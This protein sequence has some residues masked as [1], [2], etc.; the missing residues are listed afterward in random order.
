MS[1]TQ[2]QQALLIAEAWQNLY[3]NQSY[4]D[5]QSYSQDN[6]V[7]AILNYV[8]V[9]YPDNFNDW[10]ANSEFVIK[11]RT[12]AWLHQNISYRIDLDIRENFIQTATRR[13]AILMLAEN[14]FYRPNRVTGASGELRIDSIKTNQPL[15]DSNSDALSNVEI[16]WNDPANPDWF[17]QFMLV[18]NA[19]L[20]PRTQ[21]GHPLSR[22]NNT[23]TR[24]D[25]YMFNSRAPSGGVYPFTIQ[26]AGTSLPFGYI[27]VTMD[28]DTGV[29]S[30]IAPNP[31]NALRILYRSDGR[32]SGSSGTGFFL[33][34]RQGALTSFDQNFTV[35]QAMSSVILGTANVDNGNVFVQQL[36]TANNVVL[37]WTEVESIFGQG[38]SFNTLNSKIQTIF[39]THTLLNDQVRVQFG[40]GKFGAIPTDR[41]RFWYR[42][43][44]PSPIAIQP[45]DITR[46]N[47]TIPY[48]NNGTLYFLTVRA[49]LVA[50][51][52]NAISTDSNITIKNNTGGAFAAQNRMVTAADYN[53]FPLSDPSILKLKTVNRTYS[54]HSPYA[55]ISDP[56][57]FYTGI[58]ILGEDGRLYRDDA[59][60]S[61]FISGL[62]SQITLDEIVLRYLTPL[63]QST[64]KFSLYY[65]RYN[66]I[67]CQGNPV[68][69]QT[70][71][72]N[73]ISS[74]NIKKSNAVI[75]VGPT[76]IDEFFYFIAGT[77]VRYN[78]LSGPLIS[79]EHIVG[80]GTA[81]DGIMLTGALAD[82]TPIYSLMPPLRN[83]FTNA[84]QSAIKSQLF[85][86]Q[87]FGLSWNQTTQAWTIISNANLDKT[88]DFSLD[89][90]GDTTN[91][92]KDG[93]W[94]IFLRYIPNSGNG[95]EWEIVDRGMG[96][97]F[98]SSRSVDFA[99]V[100]TGPLV[101]PDT[102][103]L[104][105][106]NV[107]I[108]G[109]NEAR[110][111]LHRLGLFQIGS[112]CPLIFDF[113]AGGVA[114]CFQ[115][116]ERVD[117]PHVVV[118]LDGQ[119]QIF[120]NDYTIRETP[121]G[122]EICFFTA[123]ARGQIVSIRMNGAYVY[124][125]QELVSTIADGVTRFYP[126]AANIRVN[127]HNTFLSL[128]GVTQGFGDYLT[129]NHAQTAGFLITPPPFVN[130][131][132]QG[133]AEAGPTTDIFT[134]S[135][136]VGDGST[137]T[138]DTNGQGETKDKVVVFI[139]G[140]WQTPGLDYN[141]DNVSSPPNTLLQFITAPA[142]N[143]SVV[144]H[145][146]TIP[147]LVRS[148]FFTAI[149]NGV[150]QQFNFPNF[151]NVQYQQIIVGL[152]GVIQRQGD[153]TITASG[154]FFS[155]AP[156][157]NVRVDVFI[158]FGALGFDFIDQ[159]NSC[160]TAYLLDDKIWDAVDV[161]L[162][163]DGYTDV[164]GIKVAPVDSNF[165]GLPDDPYEFD[166]ILIPD[167]LTDLVLWRSVIEDGF[168]VWNPIDVTTVPKGTYGFFERTNIAAGMP[169]DETKNIA[170]DIHLDQTT[171]KWLIAD[172]DSGNWLVAPVQADFMSRTGRSALK[173]IWTHYPADNTRIDP[174]IS[175]IMDV[176]VL[177]V[178]YDSAY[179][180]WVSSGFVGDEPLAP[181]A[182]SL[183]DAYAYLNNFRMTDDAL[184]FHPIHYRPLFGA[185]AET[186][187]QGT[188]LAIKSSGSSLSDNDLI[189]RIINAIDV[190]FQA[191]NWN[192]GESFFLTEL[193]AFTHR[194]TA[195][196]LQSIVLVAKN[197]SPFGDLFQIRSASDELFISV[198]QPSDIQ[199]VTS[200]NNDNLQIGTLFGGL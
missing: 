158:I 173:F 85:N 145:A 157:A 88:E 149:A 139:D 26:V 186:E 7:N 93:S 143:T 76:A 11:V 161:E 115:T 38:V 142:P 98:E 55:K 191:V 153:Y 73:G 35:P 60:S 120:T 67:L 179:R 119:L 150:V 169:F 167:G 80:D 118:L 197:G 166:D 25:L 50:P 43:V 74:G 111:S 116:R 174:A 189:L 81:A 105:R 194:V 112:C 57:G 164:D 15:V 27:N 10:I 138:F 104:V 141:L 23:P 190:F 154:I 22:F 182:E 187:L 159:N 8:Q 126:I 69:S 64:D 103:R 89:N 41:F 96:I 24:T 113:T 140:I 155:L 106:D 99:Y 184:I 136:Y 52:T 193:I 82:T 3:A 56:T 132:V 30:E 36:D 46:Q 53:L 165:D 34:I 175:N 71:E 129:S 109:V 110:D 42:V 77:F 28:K 31:S 84:E 151:H 185:V 17:E 135:I 147:G 127:P 33:P 68:W 198:A 48:V 152:N 79:V 195:P 70:S 45:I 122:D 65:T 94:L 176:F 163:P 192:L 13:E 168:S 178:S 183:Q 92:E 108:L 101:D 6:L 172:G 58:R 180:Q 90:Q 130:V 137:V 107:N 72:V 144:I 170:G 196:D 19:A 121:I 199:V 124:A 37:N 117:Q 146:A 9:N 128:D 62:L 156:T 32:G 200:F 49:S 47:F 54:G 171:N 20:T 181:T 78:N 21:F 97:F 123:P 5:F 125:T 100:N 160:Y 86:L 59:R 66:E 134:V 4:V 75:P 114:K 133:Y 12:L 188:F 162:T 44:N 177:P 131:R 102:G 16:F 18:I 61:Q 1:T 39:E 29:L 40:D 91:T 148:S 14:V 2:R 95:P 63:I 83:H 87:D 51:I